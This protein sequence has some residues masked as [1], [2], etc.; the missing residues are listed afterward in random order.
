MEIPLNRIDGSASSSIDIK[1]NYEFDTKGETA[2][3]AIVEFAKLKQAPTSDLIL[4][5]G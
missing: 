5:I 4:A 2:L 3:R 1:Y